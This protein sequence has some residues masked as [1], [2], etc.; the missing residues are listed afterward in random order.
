MSTG[1]PDLVKRVFRLGRFHDVLGDS[2]KAREAG[3]SFD[4]TFPGNILNDFEDNAPTRRL[5][6]VIALHQRD[7]FGIKLS[8]TTLSPKDATNATSPV[9]PE[10]SIRS[11]G[12]II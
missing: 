6:A 3:F 5:L 1:I 7:P 2:L 11:F 12:V 10:A 8:L 9:I 4:G